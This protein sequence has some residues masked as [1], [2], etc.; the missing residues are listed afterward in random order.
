MI[1]ICVM[2]SCCVTRSSGFKEEESRNLQASLSPNFGEEVETPQV[3]GVFFF[4]LI[5]ISFQDQNL[6][7][8]FL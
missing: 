1:A 6:L 4:F 3:V 7:Q 8:Y 5:C 2:A